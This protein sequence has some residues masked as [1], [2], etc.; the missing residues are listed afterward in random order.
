[1][2]Q[3][4]VRG[5]EPVAQAL[6]VACKIHEHATGSVLT[7]Q[8]DSDNDIYFMLSGR[9]RVLINE[10]EVATRGAGQH[11]GEMA[12]VD[13]SSRRIATVVASE[14][15]TYAQVREPDFVMIANAHPFLWRQIGIELVK[16]LDERRKFHTSPNTIPQIFV[17]SSREGLTTAQALTSHIDSTLA[18]VSLWSEGV[19][20]ASHFPMEDL[21]VRLQCSD[22]AALVATA[23]DQ[24]T[25]RG[26]SKLAPRDNIV[27]ELGLFMGA[28]TRHRTFLV[29][30]SCADLKIPSDLLGINVVRYDAT[31]LSPVDATRRAACEISEIIK[32]M[33]SR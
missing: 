13:P 8:G 23:D 21:A 29:V 1:L 14:P 26:V 22:F 20:G 28:I 3:Q 27:F 2:Q 15:S 31:A 24:V 25:S 5:D 6:A 32:R 12:L 11:V 33:R 16:R 17:G 18:T 7:R 10:R 30:P 19:F 4:L 9:V